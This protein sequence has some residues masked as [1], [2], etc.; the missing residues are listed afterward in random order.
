M[1]YTLIVSC[2]VLILYSCNDHN[3]KETQEV[4][5]PADTLSTTLAN[6]PDESIFN[7]NSKWITQHNDSITLGYFA[8]KLLLLLW[9][10]QIANQRAQG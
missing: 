5:T 10:L 9:Y 3:N 8:N 7:L 2:A 6:L 1:K 4:K